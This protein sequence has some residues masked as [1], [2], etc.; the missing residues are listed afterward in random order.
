MEDRRTR[1]AEAFDHPPQQEP[2]HDGGHGEQRVEAKKL[3]TGQIE[4][5]HPA[6]LSEAAASA[7]AS[8]TAMIRP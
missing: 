2:G 1:D 6:A 8:A 4:R 5:I 3:G 7:A